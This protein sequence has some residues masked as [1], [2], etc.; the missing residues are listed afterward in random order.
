MNKVKF[1]LKEPNS[2]SDTL[3]YLFYNYNSTRF[4]Y[5]TGEKI[6]PKYWN[7]EKERAR[8]TSKFPQYIEFNQRL[9]NFENKFYNCYRRL[10]NDGVTPTTNRLRDE[11]TDSL[12]GTVVK[13][14]DDFLKWLDKEIERRKDSRKSGSVKVYRTLF[15]HLTAF[16]QRHRIKLSFDSFDL[17]FYDKFERYL[18]DEVRLVTNS[19]GKQIKTLKTFLNLA[20][21]KGFKVNPQYRSKKF[22]APQETVNHIFLNSKELKKLAELDLMDKP[23]LD[24]VRDS[25]LI[26]CH[27]GL[28]FSDF[29]QLKSRNLKIEEGRWYFLVNTQKTN[30]RVKIPVKS[31]VKKIWN[32]Y[33]GVLPRAISNQNM[34]KYLKELGAL[35]ELNEP[36]EI[37]RTRGKET[38]KKVAQKHQLI[39]SHTAR[40]SFA[41]N[42][43]AEGIPPMLIMTIT[44]HRT[45]SAF[46]KYIKHTSDDVARQLSKHKFFD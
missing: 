17:D 22:K 26:G 6:N 3:I 34:N 45:E 20:S 24:R 35:A 4:K 16:S 18:L 5:S 32:K 23:Y 14:E 29:T 38:I 39:S 27:T 12:K 28:R 37:V 13:K 46:L 42:A 44:G 40:R 2:N 21:E 9:S 1:L 33:E 7:K 10:V 8:T 11:L 30:R 41:T 36:I 31:V 43:F 19:F 15:N 25:F